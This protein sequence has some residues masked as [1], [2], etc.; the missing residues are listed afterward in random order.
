M[1]TRAR[2]GGFTLVEVM[3]ALGILAIV[4]V[5]LLNQR[6]HVVEEAGRSRDARMAWALASRKMAELELDPVIWKGPGDFSNGDFHELS[7][8]AAGFR[9]E[10]R[11]MRE[12]IDVSEPEDA[13]PVVRE[14]FRLTLTVT[15]PGE[16]EGVKLE[17]Y[18]PVYVEKKDPT[19]PAQGP[20]APRPG[21]NR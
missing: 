16:E 21:V 20:A 12:E 1:K 18:V 5:T 11:A 4:S 19:A 7:P 17:S 13:A 14:I 3:L 15:P 2:N 8:E 6:V 9:W 10:Y